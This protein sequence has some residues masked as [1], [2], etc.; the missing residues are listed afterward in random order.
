MSYN[1]QIGQEVVCV[2]NHSAEI[3]KEE[4]LRNALREIS[5]KEL[6]ALRE[7]YKLKDPDMPDIKPFIKNDNG[8][9]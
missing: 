1:F 4:D 2:K 9:L 5:K 7:K 3:V 6:P 8:I